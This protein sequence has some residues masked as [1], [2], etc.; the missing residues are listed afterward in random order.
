MMVRTWC[1][2]T[3]MISHHHLPHWLSCTSRIMNW[4]PQWL[5]LNLNH[6]QTRC[7]RH[8]PHY[9]QWKLSQISDY[10]SKSTAHPI[11]FIQPSTTESTK[12]RKSKLSALVNSRA[13]SRTPQALD[14]GGK[15]GANSASVVTY[16]V[17][18]PSTESWKSLGSISMKS[19]SSTST[20]QPWPQLPAANSPMPS[21]T[22]LHV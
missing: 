9:L 11:A 16:P 8:L 5:H 15:V 14:N 19:S 2:L 4:H 18:C 3:P 10:K 13:S 20:V 22:S 21:S 6:R 7:G 1:L 12:S 17:L